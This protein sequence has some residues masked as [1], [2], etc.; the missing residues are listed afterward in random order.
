MEE[1]NTNPVIVEGE[2]FGNV[3]V[4]GLISQDEDGEPRYRLRCRCGTD[5]CTAREDALLLGRVSQCYDCDELSK[6]SDR[7]KTLRAFRRSLGMSPEPL[8]LDWVGAA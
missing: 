5:C 4:V 8:P 1:T 2:R 3:E 6:M 7:E